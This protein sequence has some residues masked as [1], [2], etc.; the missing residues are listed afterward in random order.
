METASEPG[1]DGTP[2]VAGFAAAELGCA[3][4]VTAGAASRLIGDALDLRHRLPRCW[5]RVLNAEVPG[6]HARRVAQATRQLSQEAAAR[7]DNEIAGKLSSLSYGRLETCLE[8]AVYKADPA[9]AEAEAELAL[10]DRFVRL[11]RTS[12][13]GLKLII[14]R[15]TAGDALYF[16]AMIARLADILRERGDHDPLDIR[17]SKALGILAQPAEA[18]RLLYEHAPPDQPDDHDRLSPPSRPIA[19]RAG[20]VWRARPD[21]DPV[22]DAEPQTAGAGC[23]S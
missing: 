14:A 6:H 7:V 2:T 9:A 12:R 11:G 5:A 22:R 21:E 8:A 19:A 20:R 23:G 13:F 4:G 18:M 15:A 1:G 3:L 16:N 17:R 10:R